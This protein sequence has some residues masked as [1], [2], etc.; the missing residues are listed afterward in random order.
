VQQLSAALAEVA[1]A[2]RADD[3]PV[4]LPLPGEEI[5]RPVTD[6]VREVQRRVGAQPAS[7]P[8]RAA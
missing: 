2:V 4:E 6:A 5:L 1:R 3:R 7:G 8:D